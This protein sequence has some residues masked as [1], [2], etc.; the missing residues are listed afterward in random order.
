[1]LSDSIVRLKLHKEVENNLAK[2]LE[3]SFELETFVK[4]KL[5]FK[6][7]LQ[8]WQICILCQINGKCSQ[9]QDQKP[10]RDYSK[11]VVRL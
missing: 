11:L 8:K 1:M 5:Q 3:F 7:Y 10:S 2:L 4:I 9:G 6:Y